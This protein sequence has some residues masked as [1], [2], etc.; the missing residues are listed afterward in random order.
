[1]PTNRVLLTPAD[2]SVA[3]E[4]VRE[5]NNLITLS[6][7]TISYAVTCRM[8]EIGKFHH[9][10]TL[11]NIEQGHW[12]YRTLQTAITTRIT[13]IKKLLLDKYNVEV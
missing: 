2:L 4:L 12:L 5:Y 10:C 3:G 1:M 7:H 13:E 11:D 8:F 6:E 9:E